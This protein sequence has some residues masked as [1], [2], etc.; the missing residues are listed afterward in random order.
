MDAVVK[1]QNISNTSITNFPQQIVGEY[2]EDQ[3][4][5]TIRFVAS[6]WNAVTYHATQWSLDSKE[7]GLPLG[8]AARA[9]IWRDYYFGIQKNIDYSNITL[10]EDGSRLLLKL[11]RGKDI[12]KYVNYTI[13]P[14]IDVAKRIP[15][16]ISCTTISENVVSKRRFLLDFQ[17]FQVDQAEMVNYLNEKFGIYLQTDS[18]AKFAK[19]AQGQMEVVDY[20]ENLS[21]GATNVAKDIYFRNYLN[22]AFV[23]GGKDALITGLIGMKVSIVN[24]Y[25]LV[26]RIPSYEAIFPPPT[27]GDQHRQD[28]YGGRLRFMTVQEVAAMY[29]KELGKEILEDI[30]TMAYSSESMPMGSFGW[31]YYN[32]IV[33]SAT[34]NWWSM[35]DRVPRIAVVEAQWASYEDY[36]GEQRQC[37]R[38]GILIGNKYL[39][40]CK[41]TENQTKDWKN[42]VNT[43]LDYMYC[44]PMSVFGKNMGIPEILYNYQNRVDALQTKLDYWINQTKGTFYLINGSYLDEGIDATQVMSDISDTRVHVTK[45]MDTDAGETV[46]KFMQQGAI[47]MPRD[48]I[49]VIN[50]ISMYRQM[51][52]DILNIPDAARGI[53]EGYVPQ[54]TLNAQIGQSNKGTRY[55]FEPIL[56]F[57]NRVMQKAVDKF[58]TSTMSNPTFEYTLIVSDSQVEQFKSSKEFGTSQYSV[59]LGFED[60]VDD[61]Y[62]QRML[63]MMFAYAQNPQSGYVLSDYS[64]IEGM[65]TKSEINNYLQQRELE[66]KQ[67]AQAQQQ[68]QQEAAMAEQEA[69]AASQENVAAIN[70]QGANERTAAQVGSKE[71]IEGAKL[72]AAQEQAMAE[73]QLPPQ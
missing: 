38:E 60:V 21:I 29:G 42:P 61:G 65:Y 71:D 36:E 73:Q 39:V 25:P 26:E 16:I 46:Q 23:E 44:S 53:I 43:D 9:M 17:K 18:G 69:M 70:N 37:L 15:K 56:T 41:K 1:A 24:G 7:I 50:Q 13:E 3:Y 51:M 31:N 12:F 66:I 54:K 28:A 32:N 52:A 19:N 48:M 30:Q 10:K 11:F 72:L 22:E 47:E 40:N 5:N 2:G 67:E 55:F 58:K 33:G 27:S 45:G 6:Q 35:A 4:L 57:Y 68:A 20:R 14:L 59:Y 34:F 8:F 64:A 62:K 63:D 49:N